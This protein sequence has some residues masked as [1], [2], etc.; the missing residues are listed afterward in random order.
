MKRKFVVTILTLL[1]LTMAACKKDNPKDWLTSDATVTPG[2]TTDPEVTTVP[3]L[4]DPKPSGEADVTQAPE[5][6]PSITTEVTA[7]PK[8]TKE[9]EKTSAAKPTKAPEKTPAAK[10]SKAPEKKP[11]AKPTTKPTGKPTSKPTAKP[12]DVPSKTPESNNNKEASLESIMEKFLADANIDIMTMNTEVSAD[13]FSWYLGIDAIDGAEGLAS[14]AMIGSIAHSIC[15]LRVADGTDAKAVAKNIKEKSNP[16]K[17]ICV[18]AEK[19]VVKQ[20]G[21]IILLIM[22]FEDIAD[23]VEANFDSLY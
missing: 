4:T 9:P 7:T 13:N 23:T 1:I 14:E 15:I 8:P 20:S 12:T 21:N 22:S 2:I 11:T 16:R 10:P 5:L 19:K 18:E 17:W 6:T 3:E